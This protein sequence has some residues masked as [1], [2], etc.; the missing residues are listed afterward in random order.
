MSIGILLLLQVAGQI[1]VPPAPPPI[2][3]GSF[4][5]E[6]QDRGGKMAAISGEL[7]NWKEA[8][9]AATAQIELKAPEYTQLSG[10]HHVSV[11]TAEILING[12]DQATKRVID[13]VLTWRY[14][15]GG[16]IMLEHRV[17]DGS[18][19]SQAYVGFCKMKLSME[20]KELP[21]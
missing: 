16:M 9:S 12:F 8:G 19:V 4:S 13:G 15:R 3:S 20:P 21:K 2:K 17:L 7:G 5:C 18:R 10:R 14:D 11:R 6:M 1:F